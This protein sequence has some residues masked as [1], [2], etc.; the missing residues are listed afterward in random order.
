MD[1]FFVPLVDFTG[2]Q[3]RSI[4]SLILLGST[5]MVF[6]GRFKFGMVVG[7]VHSFFEFE[8]SFFRVSI[9][10]FEVFTGQL[11]FRVG[12]GH[13]NGHMDRSRQE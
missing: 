8:P 6:K 5:I 10:S 2:Q 1:K 7:T 9:F 11:V 13:S 3:G 4:P 12:I